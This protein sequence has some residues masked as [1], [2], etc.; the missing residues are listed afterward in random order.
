MEGED[1]L[2]CVCYIRSEK[3]RSEK[4][5]SGVQQPLL[6]NSW[7]I[8]DLGFPLR[9]FTECFQLFYTKREREKLFWCLIL[10]KTFWGSSF[11]AL[12]SFPFSLW[13]RSLLWHTLEHQRVCETVVVTSAQRWPNRLLLPLLRLSFRYYLLLVYTDM[14]RISKQGRLSKS[15]SRKNKS[16]KG[17]EFFED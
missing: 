11:L 4:G 13:I 10:L 5:V 8:Y 17:E 1:V 2:C 9:Q 6:L 3:K 7:W 15:L 16:K 12:A 14:I